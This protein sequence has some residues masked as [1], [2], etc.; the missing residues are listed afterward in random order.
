MRKKLIFLIFSSC[1]FYFLS[2]IF[3]FAAS[4]YDE[5]LPGIARIHYGGGGDWYNDREIIPNLMQEFASQT[6]MH[7]NMEQ[8]IVRIGSEIEHFPF[9]FMTGHGNIDFSASEARILHDYLLNGGFLYVDDDYGMDKFFRREIKKVFPQ[10]QLQEL[11]RDFPLFHLFHTFAN[12]LPKIHEHDGKRPQAF[13]IFDD[14]GRL[15]VLY[16]YESNVSDGWADPQ[17]HNDPPSVRQQALQMGINI[18]LFAFT[19]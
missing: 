15:M 19:Q 16:T 8:A 9:V 6:G 18:L 5:T 11:P 4:E 3:L 1:F 13:G 7:C 17:T 2:P 14:N 10:R 12:G